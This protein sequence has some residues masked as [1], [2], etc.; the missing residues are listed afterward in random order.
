M[1]VF[2]RAF[3]VVL[4][5]LAT[6]YLIVYIVY[7]GTAKIADYTFDERF[8]EDP[9]GALFSCRNPCRIRHNNGG[10][11][12]LFMLAAKALSI[13][14]AGHTKVVIDGDCA[15]ACAIFADF[16][17]ANICITRRAAFLFHKA[18]VRENGK[19]M[20]RFDPPQSPDIYEWVNDH[21]GF[22]ENKMLRMQYSEAQQFWRP[23]VPEKVPIPP[24]DPRGSF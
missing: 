18:S 17:R 13:G 15:S 16:A 14:H 10:A 11:I 6:M 22:P 5:E 20:F 19:I 3:G 21:Y 7:F 9:V 8:A 4:Y 1:G 12:T 2:R 23:C 24:R